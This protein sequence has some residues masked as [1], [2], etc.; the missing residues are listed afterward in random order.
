MAL[1]RFRSGITD[2]PVAA[3]SFAPTPLAM[4]CA[5]SL[6]LPSASASRSFSILSRS[7]RLKDTASDSMS[8]ITTSPRMSGVHCEMSRTVTC[9]A[10]RVSIGIGWPS[11]STS[12][13]RGRRTMS[14]TETSSGATPCWANSA[15]LASRRSL[16]SFQAASGSGSSDT[17]SMSISP[18]S[19]MM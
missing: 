11:G 4:F 7:L 9:S 1:A 19:G 13:L 14:C 2:T 3:P 5:L 8:F 18:M 6:A 12:T 15:R 17:M 10:T 16:T